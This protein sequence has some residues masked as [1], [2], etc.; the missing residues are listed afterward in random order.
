MPLCFTCNQQ[1]DHLA[2]QHH[3]LI[4]ATRHIM[5]L[6]KG[7]TCGQCIAGILSPKTAFRLKISAET[8]VELLNDTMPDFPGPR[9]VH[10]ARQ[11]QSQ[12]FVQS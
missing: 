5:R 6:I 9:S 3:C 4:F 2:L 11:F 1:E 10:L 7:C 12:M 8:S